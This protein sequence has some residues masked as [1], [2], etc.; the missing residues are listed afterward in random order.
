MI[1]AIIILQNI[2]QDTLYSICCVLDFIDN[3]YCLCIFPE[4]TVCKNFKNQGLQL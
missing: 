4:R 2:K 3:N 1:I